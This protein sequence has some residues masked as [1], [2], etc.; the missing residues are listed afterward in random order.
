MPDTIRNFIRSLRKRTITGDLT[1][2]LTLSACIVMLF[3]GIFNYSYSVIQLQQSLQRHANNTAAKMADIL[4]VPLWKLDYDTI[5]KIGDSFLQGENI[6][7]VQIRDEHDQVFFSTTSTEENLIHAD[8][9]VYYQSYNIGQVDVYIST[10]SIQQL[11]FNAIRSTLLAVIIVIL[12]LRLVTY[13]MLQRFLNKPLQDLIQGL[14]SIADNKDYQGLKPVPQEDINEIIQRVNLLSRQIGERVEDLRQSEERF[15]QVV[16]SIGDI[17]YQIE[18]PANAPPRVLYK[19]PHTEQLTG[20]PIN[21]FIN[22]YTFWQRVVIHPEDYEKGK[23]QW[24]RMQQ[25][26]NSETEYRIIGRDEQIIWVRDNA[27]VE[28]MEGCLMIYGVIS[29]ISEHKKVEESLRAETAE[30]KLAEQELRKYQGH[31]EELVSARTLELQTLNKELESFAYSVSHDLRAPLR[32]IDGFSYAMMEDFA[33]QIPPEALDY[34]QRVRKGTQHMSEL[35]DGL[36]RLSRLTRQPLTLETVRP[37]SIIQAALEDLSSEKNGRQI[38][39]KFGDL[40]PCEA[41]PILLRQVYVNLLSNAIKYTRR[42]NSACIELGSFEQEG[43]RV[44]F[45]RD[46]GIGFDTQYADKLF[47]VFQRLHSEAEFSGTGVGLA[48]VQRIVHRHGGRIWAQ[49]QP[50]QTT[51]YFTVS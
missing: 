29:D 32:H 6:A 31:L 5:Q 51:F 44:Y 20:Y 1:N 3:V 24:Q 19:S 46:N 16:T 12:T 43:K 49:S 23:Q 42:Q 48:I 15:R 7:S 4:S 25:G 30:R 27:R 35:I 21:E 8:A 33:D 38:E 9:P 18:V 50:D 47:G 17:L 11:R 22:D 34:L 39:F 40:P 36:L 26:F 10:S 41:D 14:D 37:G 28:K 2:S 45:V 13:V